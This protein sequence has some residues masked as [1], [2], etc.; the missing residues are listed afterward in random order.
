MSEQQGKSITASDWL[1]L[2]GDLLKGMAIL[3]G[4]GQFIVMVVRYIGENPEMFAAFL[5]ICFVLAMIFA[6]SP[7]KEDDSQTN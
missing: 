7:K 1:R 2:V 6:S 3:A 5:L 4:A